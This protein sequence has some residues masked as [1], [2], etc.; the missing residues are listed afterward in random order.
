MAFELGLYHFGE[1]TPDPVTGRPPA[2]G[3]RLRQ[4]VEQAKA[5]DEAGLD[6]FAVGEHH[7]TDFAVSAPAVVLAAMAEHT[8]DIRS[9]AP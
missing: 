5:A 8:R 3:V 4:L 9:P 2:P 6:V 7:R 1:L